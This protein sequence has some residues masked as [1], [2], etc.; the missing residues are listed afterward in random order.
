MPEWYCAYCDIAVPESA[1]RRT[2]HTDCG[3]HVWPMLGSERTLS[4][5]DNRESEKH[6]VPYGW[7]VTPIKYWS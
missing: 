4:L 7:Q 2:R 3:Q 5:D 1:V 6:E